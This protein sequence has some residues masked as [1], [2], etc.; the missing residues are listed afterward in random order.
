MRM[1]SVPISAP[2]LDKLRQR[3]ERERRRPQD[4]A[5]VI[6]ERALDVVPDEVAPAEA[7]TLDLKVQ[8]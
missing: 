1:I 4:E 8:A 7:R 6:I 3:A 5:A 2:A